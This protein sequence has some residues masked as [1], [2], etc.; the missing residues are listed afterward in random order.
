MGPE[1][2]FRPW[3]RHKTNHRIE[4]HSQQMT[5]AANAVAEQKSFGHLSHRAPVFETA[6]LDF[7]SLPGRA[8]PHNSPRGLSK[9]R[10]FLGCFVDQTKISPCIDERHTLN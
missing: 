3:Q 10:P 5:S 7:T 8:L 1:P 2:K 4:F 6:E 9:N